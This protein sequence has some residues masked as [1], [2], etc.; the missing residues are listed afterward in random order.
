MQWL[1]V[2]YYSRHAVVSRCFSRVIVENNPH[3]WAEKGGKHGDIGV[4][5]DIPFECHTRAGMSVNKNRVRGSRIDC[6]FD[7]RNEALAF[8]K[9]CLP[10]RLQ[11]GKLRYVY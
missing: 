3:E 2:W 9:I 5:S 8:C 6:R 10:I 7:V 4:N 11:H 1:I